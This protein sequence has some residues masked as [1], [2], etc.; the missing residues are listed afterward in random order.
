M[1]QFLLSWESPLTGGAVQDYL[2]QY[3]LPNQEWQTYTDL[4]TPDTSGFVS[5]LDIC[6]LYLFRVAAIS[7]LGTGIP[8][9]TNTPSTLASPP[10]TPSN[11]SVSTG[12]RSLT[13]VWFPLVNT[14]CDIIDYSI[15]YYKDN[16]GVVNTIKTGGDHN[17][18][19]LFNLDNNDPYS[20]RLASV[21]VSGTGTYTPWL[22]GL[23][24]TVAPD[25]LPDFYVYSESDD[26]IGLSWLPPN[27]IYD[28]YQIDYSTQPNQ[29]IS[30]ATLPPNT[31][32]YSFLGVIPE[33]GYSLRIAASIRSFS[34]P[35][36]TRS[37][38]HKAPRDP[39]YNKTRLLLRMGDL[40]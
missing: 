13:L 27:S 3:S 5:G 10:P 32:Y 39:L 15:Q 24:P 26:R 18:Y 7:T 1:K 30:L 21:N 38:I 4:V 8:T 16:D 36:S 35:F 11:L 22:T 37:I 23:I 2:I 9:S 20:L 33:S 40:S 14:E 31:N 19:I 28:S 29:W 12:N 34:S 6:S 25:I 17:G